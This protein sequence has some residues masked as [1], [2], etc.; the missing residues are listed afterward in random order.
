MQKVEEFYNLNEAKARQYC[1]LCD[2]PEQVDCKDLITEVTQGDPDL[3][4]GKVIVYYECD[5]CKQFG[6][7]RNYSLLSEI[8]AHIWNEGEGHYSSNIKSINAEA[9]R[10]IT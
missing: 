9:Q 3:L 6:L 4:G 7:E 8:V 2:D 1:N 5:Y 10:D